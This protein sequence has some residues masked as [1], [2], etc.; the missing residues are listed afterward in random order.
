MQVR[1]VMGMEE[2]FAR[3]RDWVGNDLNFNNT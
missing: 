2:E 3:A 1:R